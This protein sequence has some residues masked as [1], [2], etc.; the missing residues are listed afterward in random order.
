[1]AYLP[2]KIQGTEG[3]PLLQCSFMYGYTPRKAS[4]GLVVIS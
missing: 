1:M 3:G 4:S 2:K